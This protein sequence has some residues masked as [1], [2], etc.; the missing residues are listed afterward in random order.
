MVA[1]R[2]ATETDHRPYARSSEVAARPLQHFRQ[3]LPGR[4]R[5]VMRAGVFAASREAFTRASRSA[6]TART[7]AF[8]PV[9]SAP[10]GSGPW[11][12]AAAARRGSFEA[13]RRHVIP[14]PKQKPIAP[15]LAPGVRFATKPQEERAEGA[16]RGARP[17]TDDLCDNGVPKSKPRAAGSPCLVG[18]TQC[19]GAGMCVTPGCIYFRH[20][21]GAEPPCDKGRGWTANAGQTLRGLVR[22]GAHATPWQTGQ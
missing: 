1:A 4:L 16:L 17:C 3:R 6:W 12:G 21:E 9:K 11:N 14:P 18:G 20:R 13:A 7:A 8:G 5:I 15:S 22:S 2:A 19:D 10:S